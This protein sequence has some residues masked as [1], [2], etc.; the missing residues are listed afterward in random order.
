MST[1]APP[2]ISSVTFDQPSYA[3]GQTVT[4]TVTYVPGTSAVTKAFT[5]TV[6]DSTTGATGTLTV[7]FAGL[8]N[9]PTTP[10]VSDSAS[11]VWTK[12]SDS[13]TVAVFTTKF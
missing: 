9:D 11:H 1:P 5:G 6:T 2:S 13:G 3:P 7:N 8:M 10:A 4:A 12:V